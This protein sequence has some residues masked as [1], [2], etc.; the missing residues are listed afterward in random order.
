MSGVAK[1]V[2]KVFTTVGK[3]VFG[4]SKKAS[5][6]TKATTATG[7]AAATTAEASQPAARVAAP[8]ERF[9]AL[10]RRRGSRTLLS[11]ER[12]NAES[13]LGGETTTLGGM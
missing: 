10:R 9:L 7:G 2:G 12:L 1:G 6:A 8:E 5:A 13:G 4:D 11:Q 3:A